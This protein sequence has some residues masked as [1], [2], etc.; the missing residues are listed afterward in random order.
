MQAQIVVQSLETGVSKTLI[1]GGSDAR[2]VPTG[3]I[4]YVIGGNAV[5]GAVRPPEA[6]GDRRSCARR[7]RCTSWTF[8]LAARPISR[9]PTRVRSS[10]CPAR[11]RRGSRT[12]CCSIAGACGA[13]QASAGRATT[14]RA[15]R[16]MA[17]GSRLKRPMEKEAVVSIYELSGAS[18]P[19]RLTFGWEQPLSALVVRR[20]ARD[21]SIRSRRRSRRVVATGRRRQGGAPHHT[22]PGHVAYARV[23]VSRRRG[24]AVQRDEGSRLVALDVLAPGSESDAVQRRE[25][26]VASDQRDVLTR[27]PLGGVPDRRSWSGD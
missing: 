9:F 21:V 18:S 17:S 7:R 22:R 23:M 27:R 16:P 11:R 20:P 10:M 2:Y 25:G 1:E 13:A 12:W 19:R 6:R 8:G 24:A 14:S 3:H 26:F 5:R 15:C 4:V